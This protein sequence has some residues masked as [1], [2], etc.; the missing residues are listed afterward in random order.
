MI[1]TRSEDKCEKSDIKEQ[2]N[3]TLGNFILFSTVLNFKCRDPRRELRNDARLSHSRKAVIVKES[4][5][6][7]KGI[8]H[9]NTLQTVMQ[10][11]TNHY[12]TG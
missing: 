8:T 9:T 5:I 3:T 4:H 10:I 12:A 6:Y 2:M 7:C 1:N 11:E